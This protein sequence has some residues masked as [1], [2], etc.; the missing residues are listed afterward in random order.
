V[1]TQELGA[2]GAQHGAHDKRDDDRVVELAGDREEV[3]HEIEQ[4]REVADQ[5]CEQQLA[6]V[7]DAL[8]AEQAAKEHEAVGDET[9]QSARVPLAPDRQQPR[10]EG[11]VDGDGDRR[12][13]DEPLPPAHGASRT[14]AS[15]CSQH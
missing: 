15:C 2:A 3:G 12:D 14:A 1:L 5:C 13:D 10:D 7:R 8:V 9:R 11:G 6:A 4:E